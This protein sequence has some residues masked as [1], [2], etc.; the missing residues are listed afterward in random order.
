MN[1]L[2]GS[3]PNINEYPPG[4][5]TV[6]GPDSQ[7]PIKDDD[8]L[9]SPKQVS[10]IQETS[11]E[12][13]INPGYPQ[14]DCERDVKRKKKR[15]KYKHSKKKDGSKR[16]KNKSTEFINEK[17]RN[18]SN[19]MEPEIDGRSKIVCHSD[20]EID[21]TIEKQND[22]DYKKQIVQPEDAEDNEKP[23]TETRSVSQIP[24]CLSC[25]G[26]TQI[27]MTG[28]PV[29][30]TEPNVGDT[31]CTKSMQS[32]VGEDYTENSLQISTSNSMTTCTKTTTNI[33][34]NTSSK[35]YR[36]N[37]CTNN[38]SFKIPKGGNQNP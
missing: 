11:T 28:S 15:K 17:E 16:D 2:N 33:G 8:I 14:I 22:N 9:N 7:G 31:H 35:Y 34:G 12:K 30:S 25:P 21:K 23:N 3:V 10:E 1:L 24:D 5:S 18:F 6:F 4:T 29:P 27:S 26:V 38:K 32:L 20:E 37:Q 13:Y 36:A 19:N